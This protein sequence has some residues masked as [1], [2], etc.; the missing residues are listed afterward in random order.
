MADKPKCKQCNERDVFAKELCSRCYGIQWRAQK[1]AEAGTSTALVKAKP[2]EIVEGEIVVDEPSRPQPPASD[3]HLVARNP[4]EMQAAQSNL[5][6]WLKNKLTT[7]EAEVRDLNASITEARNNN[8]KFDALTRARNRVIQLE[9]FYFKALMAVEAGYV[10]IPEFP[11]DVFAIRV[12][13]ANV[14]AEDREQ[15]ST[16]GWPTIDNERPDR[17]PAGAGEYR[18]P[19]QLVRHYEWKTKDKDGKEV[20]YRTTSAAEWQDEVVF[21][22]IAARPGVMNATAEAMTLKVFDQIGVCRPVQQTPTGRAISTR[23]KGDPLILGQ[24]LHERASGLRVIS[25]IIAWHLNLD[26]L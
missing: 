26:E 6:A 23:G 8:W 10:M 24:I 14:R 12:T 11:L 3:V 7:V 19:S 17:A 15:T 16:W 13:R 5:T 21:P 18:N 4:Q 9:T 2:A 22:M 20:T 25:F 1:K